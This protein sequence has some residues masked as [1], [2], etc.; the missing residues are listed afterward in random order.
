MKLINLSLLII[1]TLLTAG[2]IVKT[3]VLSIGN[4]SGVSNGEL[5]E[6]GY[7][8]DCF[9]ISS[10]LVKPRYGDLVMYLN[11]ETLVAHKFIREEDDYYIANL[12]L[13]NELDYFKKEDFKGT[14]IYFKPIKTGGFLE[15]CFKEHEVIKEDG[16]I[17][18][19]RDY[20]LYGNK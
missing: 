15:S 14:I 3:G 17:T 2:I 20:E 12:G 13:Y 8:I 16:N 19:K 5:E 1:I 9:I 7:C 10:I 6:G 4:F 11:N 18:C